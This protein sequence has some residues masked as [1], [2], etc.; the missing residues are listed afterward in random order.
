MLMGE[1][2]MQTGKRARVQAGR[3]AGGQVGRWADA[4]PCTAGEQKS[5][6][7]Q[8]REGQHGGHAGASPELL[9]LLGC[10]HRPALL[11]SRLPHLSYFCKE[12]WKGSG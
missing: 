2:G 10:E 12:P 7:L 8:A 1:A 5:G 6:G 3:C 9:P 11:P 4:V